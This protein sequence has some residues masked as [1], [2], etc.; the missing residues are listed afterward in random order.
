MLTAIDVIQR[1]PLLALM[2]GNWLATASTLF[3]A[4]S[5]SAGW[6]DVS[7]RSIDM[8]YLA[9]RL[10]L[11]KKVIFIAVPTYRKTYSADSISLSDDW[12]LAALATLDKMLSFPMPAPVR[13]RLLRK[14]TMS[15][16]QISDVHRRR[17]ELGP[18][19]RFHL[20]SLREPW[21]FFRYALYT[22]RLLLAAGDRVVA[23]PTSAPRRLEKSE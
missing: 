11:E 23:V 1:D 7:I 15:A 13:R 6:F 8:T 9:F 4:E 10:A 16:H 14:C 19:W 5:V 12:V 22:R 20:R 2:D 3:R 21:G 17:G 18:A